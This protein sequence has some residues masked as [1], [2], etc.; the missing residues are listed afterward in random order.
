MLRY[1]RN[2]AF[3]I[4]I[5][6]RKNFLAA[7]DPAQSAGNTPCGD[8]ACNVHLLFFVFHVDGPKINASGILFTNYPK[9]IVKIKVTG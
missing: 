2:S 5:G 3:G 8:Q 4:G 6:D 7:G 1:Y 9:R